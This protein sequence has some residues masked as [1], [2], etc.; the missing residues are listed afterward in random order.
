MSWFNIFVN[1]ERVN[2]GSVCVSVS[3][4]C[5][6]DGQEFS[7]GEVY[8]M[9]QCWMCQCRGG[10]SFCSKAE[11]AELDCDNFYVPGGECCPVCKGLTLSLHY[12]PEL[13]TLHTNSVLSASDSNI[14]VIKPHASDIKTHNILYTFLS[15]MEV[16]SDIS[17]WQVIAFQEKL[18]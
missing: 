7:E 4:R 3:S 10:I 15:L 16:Y 5:V 18:R 1:L 11:C 8:R 12:T 6:H 2:K 14:T 9:D 13:H 17:H